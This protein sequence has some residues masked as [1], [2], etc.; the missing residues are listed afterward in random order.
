M[1]NILLLSISVTFAF[2]ILYYAIGEPSNIYNPKA[3][4]ANYTYFLAYKRVTKYE[5]VDYKLDGDIIWIKKQML[6]VKR[7]VV[8]NAMDLFTYEYMLGIC[9]ICTFFW[10][11]FLFI[12][13][14]SLLFLNVNFLLA[15]TFFISSQ[16]L[17]KILVKWL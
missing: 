2:R 15:F 16:I 13:I 12:L 8:S 7:M 10:V 6:D 11:S 1:L 14:P 17:N 4:F 3:I 9:P 5:S